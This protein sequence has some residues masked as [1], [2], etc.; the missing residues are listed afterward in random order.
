M[1]ARSYFVLF[2]RVFSQSMNDRDTKYDRQLRLWAHDG[3]FKLEK[4]HVCLIN[5]T[6]V[7]AETLKNLVLPGVGAFTII[8]D[9]TVTDDDLSG[10]LLLS[11]DDLGT[12]IAGA[13]CKGLLELNPDVKGFAVEMNLSELPKSYWNDFTAV[14]VSEQLPSSELESLKQILWGRNIPLLLVYTLGFYGSVHIVAKETTIVETHDPSRVFDLRVDC[15]WT[16][17]QEFAD[18]FDMAQLDDTDHSHV[19]YIVIFIKALQQ[20]RKDHQGKTPQIF[21]EKKSFRFDYVEAMARN[22]NTETNFIEASQSVHRAL[23]ISAMPRSTAKLFES[24]ELLS[25]TSKTPVFWLH[26]LALK[27]FVEKN[28]GM[29]PLP[30]NLPDMASTT[31]NY[32]TLLKI[33]RDKAIQDQQNFFR[34]LSNVYHM[35]GLQVDDISV[36]SIATFCKNAAFIY[37]SYGSPFATSEGLIKELLS[38]SDSHHSTLAIYFAMLALHHWSEGTEHTYDALIESFKTITG[39][40]EEQLTKDIRSAVQEVYLHHL[41]SYLNT[42]SLLGG[43]AGQEILKIATLQYIPLNNLF[44]FDGVKSVSNKWTVRY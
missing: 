34:E 3:Q 13:M 28:G 27:R 25:V 1:E 20:W 17:L 16:E 5:A 38:P 30:G 2:A 39:A 37:V 18:S 40:T 41:T 21:S 43:I 33:Y 14:I 44:V 31:S 19:P 24:P 11:E 12:G 36:E 4:A 29:L 23:Q 26:I 15:P 35:V 32:I 22:I 7:G 42:C 6:P 8:D 10:N 9:R